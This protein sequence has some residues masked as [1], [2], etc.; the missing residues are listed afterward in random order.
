MS[1]RVVVPERLGAPEALEEG[2]GGQNHLLDPLD[3][4]SRAR[5]RASDGG[6]VLHDALRGLR[7]SCSTLAGDDDA[8]ILLVGDHV[9]VGGLGD[10]VDVRR[11]LETVLAAVGDED[12]V[13]VDGEE[14]EGV[15]GDEDM[16]D[17]GLVAR[18]ESVRAQAS[19][20]GCDVE[21]S[22]RG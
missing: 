21:G 1:T 7:L 14:A 13:G 9:V 18:G 2:V 8:L 6:N 11:D 10:G 16:A 22:S 3:S 15:D 12:F 4:R 20:G 5:V 19:R 17:V